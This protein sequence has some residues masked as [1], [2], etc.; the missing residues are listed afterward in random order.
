SLYGAPY[1]NQETLRARG[2]TDDDLHNIEKAL[3]SVFEIGFA[4]NQW[5]LGEAC[6]QRLGFPGEKHNAAGFDLI[7]ELGF[8]SEEIDAANDYICGTMTLEGAPHLKEEHYP[9]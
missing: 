9:V 5:T 6:L 8:T 3:P 4:F 7:R 2:F 1:I